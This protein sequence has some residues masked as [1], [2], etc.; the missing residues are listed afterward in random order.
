M[1]RATEINFDAI[2]GPT[3]NYAGLSPGN[4]ASLRH[5]NQASN[6]RQAALEG[7][8]KMKFLADLGIAQA[9]L[10]PH[11]RPD[12]AT[13][14]RLGFAGSD[15]RVLEQAALHPQ[16]L[17]ACGSASAMWAA[18]AATVSPSS[19]AADDRVHFTPANLTAQFHRSLEPPTTAAVLRAIFPDESAFAHHPPL[20]GSSHF[21]DEGA[22]NHVRL[23]ASHGDSAL[24]IFV[25]GRRAFGLDN[26][27]PAR[28]MARQ[29]L[30]ASQAVARLH[31]LDARNLLFFRQNPAAI[32]AGAFH[33]DVVTVGNEN[34]LLFHASAFTDS[35]KAVERI[36]QW[37]DS[38]GQGT[39]HLIEADESQVPLDD[40]IA[41]YLF[42]SQLVTLADQTMA[43]IAPMESR[44]NPRARQ[45]IEELLARNTPVRHVHYVDVRQSMNNGGGP[46]CLRLRVVLTDRER[47]LVN[48]N[49][50]LTDSLYESLKDWIS[51]HYREHLLPA[52]LADPKL[53]DESRRALDELTHLLNLGSIYPFQRNACG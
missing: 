33:N 24:E 43:L 10:P 27:A 13:L 20:P 28:F 25:H 29:T 19:D 42:N 23:S 34:V 53:L 48:S 5:S 2:P 8:A 9:V 37:F 51:R 49:V 22:A 35:A 3:H 52:D 18:N 14:R 31:Q 1:L 44:D 17:A 32:D 26:A 15:A 11:E 50:F 38:A 30:E 40:A 41:S 45:W 7:L 4:L 12:M 46:A 6:P 47:S 16:I 36:R 39:P 21:A